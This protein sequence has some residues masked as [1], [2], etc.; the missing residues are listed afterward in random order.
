ELKAVRAEL[1]KQRAQLLAALKKEQAA[2]DFLRK[3]L[4]PLADE[5]ITSARRAYAED[6]VDYQDYTMNLEQA[7][8]SRWEYIMRLRQYHL[9]RLELEFLSG[10]R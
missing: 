6:A 4:L 3:E 2:L 1:E 10:K 8:D 7:L 5:Q 9:I